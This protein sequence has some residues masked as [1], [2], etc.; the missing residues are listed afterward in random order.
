MNSI[1]LLGYGHTLC[2]PDWGLH[3]EVAEFCRV[4]YML[5]GSCRYSDAN[6]DLLLERGHLYLL[7]QYF[8]YS[9]SQDLANPFFVLW[10]HIRVA[11]C[12]VRE[13]ADIPVA[14][15]SPEWHILQTLTCLTK[16]T[17]IESLPDG[18]CELE[19]QIGALLAVLTTRLDCEHDALFSPLD[20][21][22]DHVWSYIH[23]ENIGDVTVRDMA[24]AANL[25]RSYFSRLFR[26]QLG[27]SPQRWLVMEKLTEAARLLLE[28]KTV[29][30]TAACV[31]YEDAKAFSRAFSQH[32]KTAPSVYHKSHMMQP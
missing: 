1:A 22:L 2:G 29:S 21:R 32:M 18:A 27:V 5:G 19:Q 30:E 31:G 24:A 23:A 16:G 15:Q 28:G 7:P 26:Q 4:Y 20:A 11:G 6:H 10:Q 9:L 17:L 25:E 3:T 14:E 13:F 8:A 12:C